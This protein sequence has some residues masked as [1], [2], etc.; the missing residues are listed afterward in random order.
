M[1]KLYDW[2]FRDRPEVNGALFTLTLFGVLAVA[3]IA[4]LVF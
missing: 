4:I 2:P 3:L 1:R